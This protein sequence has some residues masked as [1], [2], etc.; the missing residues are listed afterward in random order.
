[1][2]DIDPDPAANTENA[3]MEKCSKQIGLVNEIN[4]QVNE[5]KKKKKKREK[6]YEQ[7]SS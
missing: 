2:L 1:M 6:C 5:K 3:Y 4:K 7:I